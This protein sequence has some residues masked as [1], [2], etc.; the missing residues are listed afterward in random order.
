[1]SLHI[2][3]LGRPGGDSAAFV[4]IDTG[5]AIHRLLF[6][7]G[8]GCLAALEFS[9]VLQ[10]DRVFFSHLHMDHIAGFD[11]L[12][13]ALFNR[14]TRLR[15]SGPEHT[16]RILHHRF[17]GY[18]WNLHH[19]LPGALVVEDVFPGRVEA[20]RYVLAEAFEIAHPEPTRPFAG[21]LVEHVDYRVEA[22]H[23]SHGTP[24]LA[25]IV[26][27]PAKQNIDPGRLL[28]SGLKPGPWLK[29]LKEGHGDPELRSRLLVETPGE[30]SAYLTDFLM[31][32]SAMERLV[33]A[34]SGCKTVV[35]ES[36]FSA[37][38]AEL[39][40]RNYHMTCV[41]AAEVARRAGV[42]ELVL[43]HLSSRYTADE[44]C[45]ML[46]DARRIFPNTRFPGHWRL[47]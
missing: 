5:Q 46:D 33:P 17:Q 13:R 16:A 10:I 6:D 4:R 43:F 29:E 36:Q 2:E 18:L 44:W 41:Q 42:G 21:W 38:D 3:V 47:G 32:E 8:E 27:T 35:C 23:M 19:G 34:L 15:L 30:S 45:R 31:D 14:E 37:A 39:A 25:F 40:V 26:R 28:E 1:M 22:L 12:F 9:E 7:C 24:S 11:S 20:W